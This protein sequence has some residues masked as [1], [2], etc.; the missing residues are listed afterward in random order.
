M[1]SWEGFLKVSS[2]ED[3]NSLISFMSDEEKKHIRQAEYEN[4]Q[5]ENNTSS[6][7][8]SKKQIILDKTKEFI[9]DEINKCQHMSLVSPEESDT[10]KYV[11]N[12]INTINSLFLAFKTN[13][14]KSDFLEMAIPDCDKKIIEQIFNEPLE[15][16]KYITELIDKLNVA[17]K[18]YYDFGEDRRFFIDK[19]INSPTITATLNFNN[20]LNVDVESPENLLFQIYNDNGKKHKYV[21]LAILIKDLKDYAFVENKDRVGMFLTT[22]MYGDLLQH[23]PKENEYYEKIYD[24]KKRFFGENLLSKS[25]EEKTE[26]YSEVC[27]LAKEFSFGLSAS[28]NKHDSEITKF[29]KKL[30]INT[31]DIAEGTTDSLMPMIVGKTI[32]LM[33]QHST[34]NDTDEKAHNQSYRAYIAIKND[35]KKN[36]SII[37][38]SIAEKFGINIDNFEFKNCS[39]QILGSGIKDIPVDIFSNPHPQTHSVLNTLGYFSSCLSYATGLNLETCHYGKEIPTQFILNDFFEYMRDVRRNVNYNPFIENL[40]QSNTIDN[41]IN[42]FGVLMDVLSNTVKVFDEKHLEE[43][44]SESNI[45]NTNTTK[46]ANVFGKPLFN[47]MAFLKT[48]D[49]T[50]NQ[51][52]I[53]HS[54]IINNIRPLQL[55]SAQTGIEAIVSLNDILSDIA[56]KHLNFDKATI[57]QIKKGKYH[58]IVDDIKAISLNTEYVPNFDIDNIESIKTIPFSMLTIEQCRDVG[59]KLREAA[60]NHGL[61]DELKKI[62]NV[63]LDQFEQRIIPTARKS[64]VKVKEVIETY[65]EYVINKMKDGNTPVPPKLLNVLSNSNSSIYNYTTKESYYSLVNYFNHIETG[66]LTTKN[67]EKIVTFLGIDLDSISYSPAHEYAKKLRSINK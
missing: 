26:F 65:W 54:F 14:F 10:K 58:S 40:I 3:F 28:T 61:T 30:K 38:S 57:N 35:L 63:I 25:V 29:I 11:A 13:D 4:H 21:E 39:L 67:L 43:N 27:D 55:I 8:E 9:Y 53:F 16:K 24:I 56:D 5:K 33:A 45:R 18:Q 44:L 23:I 48:S 42:S 47:L 2:Y 59:A 7:L 49:L 17:C 6:L 32:Y 64:P 51:Y 62:G 22:V 37:K 15:I 31:Q 66:N 41:D 50:E 12:F 20:Q 19:F 46:F 52:D 60:I 36:D 34:L 1:S